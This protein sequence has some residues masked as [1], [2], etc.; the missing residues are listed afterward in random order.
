MNERNLERKEKE[1]KHRHIEI[2]I[3]R[4]AEAEGEKRDANLTEEGEKHA[5]MAAEDLLKEIAQA[6]GGVIKIYHSP[7]LRTKKTADKFESTIENLIKEN[8]SEFSNTRL[9]KKR[10]REKLFGHG[11]YGDLKEKAEKGEIDKEFIDYWLENPGVLEGKSPEIIAGRIL[12]LVD[13]AEKI[14]ERLDEGESIYFVFITHEMPFVALVNKLSGKNRQE[15]GG[16]I[17]NLES[18]KI[19]LGTEEKPEFIFRDNSY[20]IKK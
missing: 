18:G 3:F 5:E 10:P 9:L 4:H 14:S 15:L 13:R 17:K 7:I 11:V 6:G 16:D 2:R 8:P 19:V 1:P 20:S 12:D